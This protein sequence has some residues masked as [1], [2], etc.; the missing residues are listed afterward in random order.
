MD[1]IPGESDPVDLGHGHTLRW[2]GWYPDRELNP[3]RAD[4][5]DVER[6][7]ALVEHRTPDGRECLSAA[8]LAGEV[9]ARIEPGKPMWDVVSWEP[10]TLS[11]SLLCRLCGDH[12]WVREGRWVPA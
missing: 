10:L 1:S 2:A 4:L 5:P 11:P 6:Y 3:H 12:G 8:T 9:Q 7:C